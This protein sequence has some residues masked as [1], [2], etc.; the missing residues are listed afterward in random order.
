MKAII[1]CNELGVQPNGRRALLPRP[2][3]PIGDGPVLELLLPRLARAGVREAILTIDRLAPLVRACFGNGSQYGLRLIYC[4]E[5][6]PPER[7]ERTFFVLNADVLTT[8]DFS[9]LLRFHRRA[10]AIATLAVH[11]RRTEI[12]LSVVHFNGDH[13]IVGY[14]ER[15]NVTHWA[16][17]GVYVFEPEA[18][19]F[20]APGEPFDLPGLLRRLLSAGGKLAG[21]PFEGYWQDL[22]RPSD[23]SQAMQEFTSMREALLKGQEDGND[24]LLTAP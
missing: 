20:L 23:Y 3:Q 1:L 7:M 21:Y 14:T 10:G 13:E 5:P 15:P 16:C 24:R 19:S 8:L 9:A 12:D 22:S 6:R 2:M 17:M 18:L 4:E 11:P